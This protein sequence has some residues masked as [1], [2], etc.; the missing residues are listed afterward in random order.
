MAGATAEE[1]PALTLSGTNCS[2]D[3]PIAQATG[4]KKLS[5]LHKP[6]RTA[7][8]GKVYFHSARPVQAS[9]ILDIPD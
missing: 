7:A 2:T 1:T 9:H 5:K 8:S 3:C 6:H 4:E